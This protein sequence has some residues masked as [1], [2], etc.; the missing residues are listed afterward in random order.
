MSWLHVHA[1]Q[2]ATPEQ[3]TEAPTVGRHAGRH[4]LCRLVVPYSRIIIAEPNLAELQQYPCRALDN[5]RWTVLPWH[6]SHSGHVC[7]TRVHIRPITHPPAAS[8]EVKQSDSLICDALTNH[9]LSWDPPLGI[10]SVL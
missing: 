9:R 4:R 7:T 3:K 6:G 2:Y 5:R 10:R 1:K 8:E